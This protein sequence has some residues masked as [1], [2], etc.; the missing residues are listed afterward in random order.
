M[1]RILLR[2]DGHPHFGR[3]LRQE[4]ERL[5]DHSLDVAF[6]RLDLLFVF[7]DE[8]GQDLH[9]SLQIRLLGCPFG[10]LKAVDALDDQLHQPVVAHHPLDIYD[11]ADLIEIIR[12][13]VV[14]GHVFGLCGDAGDEFFLG[15]KRGL[16]RVGRALASD[17]QRNDR[18]RKQRRVLQRQNGDLHL[19]RQFDLLCLKLLLCWF[20]SHKFLGLEH[21]NVPLS[22]L[23][24]KVFSSRFQH[25]IN[26]SIS[27][28]KTAK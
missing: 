26:A 14:A 12:L 23:V 28:S 1:D 2:C 7:A 6:E 13:G 24:F 10:D 17:R 4:S 20:V 5:L 22:L 9:F 16:D 18:F 27:D 3:D 19:L 8:L 15:G 21:L 11:R 25:S